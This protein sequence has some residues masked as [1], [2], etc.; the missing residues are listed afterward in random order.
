MLYII[1]L[2]TLVTWD[3]GKLIA[4]YLRDGQTA[5][6]ILYGDYNCYIFT[7]FPTTMFPFAFLYRDYVDSKK[8]NL[9][10]IITITVMIINIYGYIY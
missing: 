5:D 7:R 3:F 4:H 8:E 10:K 6:F 9:I 2:L 1:I